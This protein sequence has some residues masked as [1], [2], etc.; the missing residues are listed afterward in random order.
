MDRDL[1]A[2]VLAITLGVAVV[3]LGNAAMAI[4]WTHDRLLHA[5]STALFAIGAVVF[6]LRSPSSLGA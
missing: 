3:G 5:T 1:I 4:L 6:M 2:W